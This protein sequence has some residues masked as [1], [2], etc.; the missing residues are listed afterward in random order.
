MADIFRLF[1]FPRLFELV[2]LRKEKVFFQHFYNNGNSKCRYD[3][4]DYNKVYK[5]IFHYSH[6]IRGKCG[7]YAIY[8]A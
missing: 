2:T 6:Y 7:N 3:E 5:I 8:E 4:Y 1:D